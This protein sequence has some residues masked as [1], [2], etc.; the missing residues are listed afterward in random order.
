MALTKKLPLLNSEAKQMRFLIGLYQEAEN[1]QSVLKLRLAA[2]NNAARLEHAANEIKSIAGSLIMTIPDKKIGA[3]LAS[4]RNMQMELHTQR[5]ID[6][7]K[8]F[9]NVPTAAF[10]SVCAAACT[11][12]CQLCFGDDDEYQACSLRKAL[13]SFLMIDVEKEFY[14]C[15]YKDFDWSED[16]D[17]ST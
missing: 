3:F 10:R 1:S 5:D 17:Q 4:T 12:K 13:D 8:D 2:T 7:S 15:P 9:T 6:V 11:E 16:L 14:H